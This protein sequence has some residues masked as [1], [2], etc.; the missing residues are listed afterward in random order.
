M[1]GNDEIDNINESFKEAI[2]ESIQNENGKG[3]IQKFEEF[4]QNLDKILIKEETDI[5][6]E[7]RVE[8][9]DGLN[10]DKMELYEDDGEDEDDQEVGFNE[11]GEIKGPNFSKL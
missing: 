3:T 1:E 9:E 7:E 11:E 4:C 5:K 8:G 10:L 2:Y 6:I